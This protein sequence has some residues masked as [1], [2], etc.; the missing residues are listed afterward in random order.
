MDVFE[1]IIEFSWYD[2]ALFGF[3]LSLS[4]A[5]GIYFGYFN[6]KEQDANEYLLGS[7]EMTVFPVSMSLISR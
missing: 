5:I 2:Y 1:K 6:K 7:N 4:T 3:I